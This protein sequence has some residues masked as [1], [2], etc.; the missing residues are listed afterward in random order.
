MLCFEKLDKTWHDR[1]LFSCGVDSLDIF[2]Q[3]YASQNQVAGNSTTHVLIDSDRPE[4]ILGFVTLASAQIAVSELMPSEAR[5]VPLF[6]VPSVRIA[7]LAVDSKFQ[8]KHYGKLLLGYSV[9]KALALRE[10]L[11][12]RALLVYAKDEKTA[13]F[14]RHFGFVSTKNSPLKLYLFI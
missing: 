11:G 6:P 8:G 14:Y 2:L 9:K 7:R 12:V 5:R 13:D 1:E 10:S 4:E 3:R